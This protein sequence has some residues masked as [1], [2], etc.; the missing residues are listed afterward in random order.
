MIP[1]EILSN[2]IDE[3]MTAAKKL[4]AG[5]CESHIGNELPGTKGWSLYVCVQDD[6]TPIVIWEKRRSCDG[7]CEG[8]WLTHFNI[9]PEIK[10][11][12]FI[13]KEA[14]TIALIKAAP[15]LIEWIEN[16]V[17]DYMI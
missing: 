16:V 17:R 1:Q 2:A 14:A 9:M 12:Q 4:P 13:K 10:I 11:K 15:D 7:Y 5:F 8:L 6:R 3:I